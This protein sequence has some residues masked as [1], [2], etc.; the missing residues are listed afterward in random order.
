VAFGVRSSNGTQRKEIPVFQRFLAHVPH[1]K[2]VQWL[3]VTNKIQNISSGIFYKSCDNKKK[4][5]Y[6]QTLE[7]Y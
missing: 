7:V 4:C 5:K 3:D 1:A 2:L 6:R